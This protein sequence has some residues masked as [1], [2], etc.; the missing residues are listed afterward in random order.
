VIAEIALLHDPL[1]MSFVSL[2]FEGREKIRK[3]SLLA[4]IDC[5]DAEGTGADARFGSLTDA[6]FPV[7]QDDAGCVFRDRIG[8]TTLRAGH[9]AALHAKHRDVGSR[10]LRV[11]P[12]LFFFYSDPKDPR[13]RGVLRLAGYQTSVATGAPAGIDD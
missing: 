9:L 2:L 13:R 6:F 10:N 11:F 5:E 4:V 3:V 7:D 1:G 8:G 12:C